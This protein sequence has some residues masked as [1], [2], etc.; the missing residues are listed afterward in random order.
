MKSIVI[1]VVAAMIGIG[2]LMAGLPIYSVWQQEQSGKAALAKATQDRQIKIQEAQAMKESAKFFAEAEV[3][4][5]RGVAEANKIIGSGLKGNDEY[6]RYLW[7]QA[8]GDK[9]DKA[10]VYIPVGNDGIPLMKDIQ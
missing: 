4:R 3:I 5:A 10:T 7:I 8:M 2:G 1:L 9:D 6:L